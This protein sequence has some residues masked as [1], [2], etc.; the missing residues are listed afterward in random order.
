MR[1][2]DWCVAVFKSKPEKVEKDLVDFYDF[3]KDLKGVK[4]LHFLIRD[5]VRNEVVFSFRLLVEPEDKKI[6]K[7]KLAYKLKTLTT[8]NKFAIDPDA[9][10]PLVKYVAWSSEARIAKYGSR[11]FSRLCRFL[12]QMSEMVVDMARKKY[13]SSA[14]RVEVVHVISWMLGCTEYGLWSKDHVEVGY[15]DRITDENHRVLKK[16]FDQ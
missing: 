10:S 7:S 16:S 15:Y 1:S 4:D 8:E 11:K 3:V 6:V 12:S 13:F 5:R 9:D 14:E 2:G